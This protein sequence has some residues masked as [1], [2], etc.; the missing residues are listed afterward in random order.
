[1]SKNQSPPYIKA[2]S[3]LP[4]LTIKAV[5]LGVVLSMI[6][7]A[8]NAYLG[9]FAGLFAAIMSTADGF[10]NIGAA[11]LVHDMPKAVPGNHWP[12]VLSSHFLPYCLWATGQS[13]ITFKLL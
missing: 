6:L 12:P 7:S 9:L 1:M 5:F 3:V 2:A 10:L 11:A 13:S 8:A 4:E